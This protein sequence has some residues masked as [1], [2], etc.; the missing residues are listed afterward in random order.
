M[1]MRPKTDEFHMIAGTLTSLLMAE[2]SKF[3]LQQWWT[4]CSVTNRR[5]LVFME[6]CSK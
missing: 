6:C 2:C 4:L 5:E 1:E 3:L